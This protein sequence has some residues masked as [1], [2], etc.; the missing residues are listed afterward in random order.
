MTNITTSLCLCGGDGLVLGQMDNYFGVCRRI[1]RSRPVRGRDGRSEAHQ[2]PQ[3]VQEPTYRDF[4]LPHL[5]VLR[6]RFC[7]AGNQYQ[8]LPRLDCYC[9]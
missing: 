1:W 5:R 3:S 7:A 6:G 9:V 2:A 4:G 8:Q